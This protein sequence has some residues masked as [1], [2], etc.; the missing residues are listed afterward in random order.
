MKELTLI[1]SYLPGRTIGKLSNGLR[2][3]ERAWLD[4]EVSISCIPE[5]VYQ[6][7]RDHSGRF[8]FYAVRDVPGRTFIE[9]H[10]GVYPKHSEGCILIG[11]NLDKRYNLQNSP[12]AL[13]RLIDEIG[14][15]S[16]TLIIRGYDP[17]IDGRF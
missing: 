10:G 13:N 11:T 15:D 5:G 1:R 9:L 14:E 3:L 12:K 7:D 4:N 2:T 17:K 8:Q 16:F 6:V